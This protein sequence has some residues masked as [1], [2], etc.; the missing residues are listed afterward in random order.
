MYLVVLGD[1]LLAHQWHIIYTNQIK[2]LIVT[3]TLQFAHNF[4]YR[5]WTLMNLKSLSLAVWMCHSF[6][7]I[8]KKHIF[9]LSAVEQCSGPF[10]SGSESGFSFPRYRIMDPDPTSDPT[11]EL[12][13]KSLKFCSTWLK[14]IK[15]IPEKL[16]EKIGRIFSLYFCTC[17]NGTWNFVCT[18]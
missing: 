1:F 3:K 18:I 10:E 8:L 9:F 7:N 4:S 11:L 14:L 6:R 2:C 5:L 17:T 16:S 15:M 13:L 12:R